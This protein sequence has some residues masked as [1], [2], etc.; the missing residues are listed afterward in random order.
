LEIPK[1]ALMTD[2]K[3]Y[4]GC[5]KLVK[6]YPDVNRVVTVLDGASLAMGKGE[7]VVVVGRSGAG[8]STLLHLLGLLDTPDSGRVT[9]DGEDLAEL[10]SARRD[11]MRNRTFGFVFQSYHLLPEFTAIEN[12]MMPAMMCGR[13]E[14]RRRRGETEKR[15]RE[16]L[17]RVGL[18][19]RAE[20]RPSQMS[21]G[22]QQRAAIARALVNKPAVLLCDEPTGNLDNETGEAV[23]G[24]L[25]EVV[26]G[27]GTTAVIVT[28]DLSLARMADRILRIEHGRLE[29]F[30]EKQAAGK[31]EEVI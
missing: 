20:H 22:E 13:G 16:L 19:D 8:K 18:A 6:R 1:K 21:G 4:F 26:R 25:R 3:P 24:M 28:H 10:P 31:K 11:E 15:A 29:E 14:W 27:T 17:G 12:A 2:S 23:N 9:L 5:E 30:R 7:M